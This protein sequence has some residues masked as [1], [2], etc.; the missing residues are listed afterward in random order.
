MQDL[1]QM[2]LEINGKSIIMEDDTVVHKS[3]LKFMNLSLN[4]YMKK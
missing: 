3:F 1:F 2:A 4:I